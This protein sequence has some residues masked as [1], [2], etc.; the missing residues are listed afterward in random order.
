VRFSIPHGKPTALKKRFEAFRVQQQAISNNRSRIDSLEREVYALKMILTHDSLHSPVVV[1]NYYAA[2]GSDTTQLRL[3]RENDLLK[4]SLAE[5]Y[6]QAEQDSAALAR[7]EKG[8][9]GAVAKGD[10]AAAKAAAD[11][12]AATEEMAHQM[13]KINKRLGTQNAILTA[14]AI[15]GVVAGSKGK[16]DKPV[17][18]TAIY[19]NDSTVVLNGDTLRLVVPAGALVPRAPGITD[20]ARAVVR[21]TVRIVETR[22]DTVRII[23][24]DTT[25]VERTVQAPGTIARDEAERQ[26]LSEP[27][28]FASGRTALGPQGR[29]KVAELAAWLGA[30]PQVRV[31]VTGVADASGSVSVNEGVAQKRADSVRQEL[32]AQGVDPARITTQ[33]KL[34]PPGSA[35]DARDRRADVRLIEGPR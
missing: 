1:N 12:A 13:E 33:R 3:Q 35:P 4:R 23:E 27:I 22:V 20:T 10:R 24:R 21:D 19:V 32:I 6:V 8:K 30:H 25:V 17:T 28:H 15:T 7:S 29:M 9:G 34:A 5:A 14:G 26:R 16:G 2:P 31:E 11:Q 18:G